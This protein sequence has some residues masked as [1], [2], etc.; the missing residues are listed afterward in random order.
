MATNFTIL[1]PGGEE[2]YID[3]VYSF[4]IIYNVNTDDTIT[5]AAWTFIAYQNADCTGDTFP[6]DT[7]YTESGKTG[8]AVYASFNVDAP[9][10]MLGAYWEY[11]DDV[12]G[13][14][15]GCESVTATW[16]SLPETPTTT[17][18]VYTFDVGT[19]IMLGGILAFLVAHW[20]VGLTRYRN[21]NSI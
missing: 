12:T 18:S 2:T 19:T 21:R 5:N 4:P 16:L 13:I 6:A 8:N 11:N 15:S 1:T 9:F 14:F 3:G 10:E 17:P 20:L 7:F